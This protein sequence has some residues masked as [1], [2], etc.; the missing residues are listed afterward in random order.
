MPCPGCFTPGKDPVPIVWKAGRATGLKWTG[1]ENLTPTGIRSPDCPA[2]I[3][4]LYQLRY[5]SPQFY[6]ILCIKFVFIYYYVSVLCMKLI[7]NGYVMFVSSIGMYHHSYYSTYFKIWHFVDCVSCITI[8][9]PTW[10]TFTFT[11]TLLC[12]YCASWRCT[13]DARNM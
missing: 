1:A 10:Y 4:S 3:K 11:I 2:C 12:L 9:Y 5:S 6:T 7:Q 8:T 13:L